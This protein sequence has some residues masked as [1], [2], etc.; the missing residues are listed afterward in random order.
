MQTLNAQFKHKKC[1][2]STFNS[3]A[4]SQPKKKCERHNK[5]WPFDIQRYSTAWSASFSKQKQWNVCWTMAA[6]KNANKSHISHKHVKQTKKQNQLCT[7]QNVH[8]R[9]QPRTN[10]TNTF[11]ENNAH[12]SNKPKQITNLPKPTADKRIPRT[13][14]HIS[15]KQT[16]W[17]KQTNQTCMKNK[18]LNFETYEKTNKKTTSITNQ[19]C[20]KQNVVEISC[21]H[22]GGQASAT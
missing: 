5:I 19:T 4:T 22:M 11:Q 21:W 6:H 13:H 10:H 8:F 7:K 18:T 1:K 16:I 3:N 20:V 17:S 15:R 14:K 12:A 9:H 2:I